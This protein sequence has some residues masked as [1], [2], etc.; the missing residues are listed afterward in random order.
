[1]ISFSGKVI[2]LDINPC[3]DMPG[4]ILKVLF[5]QSGKSKGPITVRGKLNGAKFLQTLVRYRGKWRMYLNTQMRNASGTDVGDKVKIEIEFDPSPREVLM[6]SE[7]N[8]AL[9]KN[10]HA[11][12]AFEKLPPSHQKEILRYLNSLKSK[13]AIERNVKKVILR[14]GNKDPDKPNILFRK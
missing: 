9:S 5:K 1:M 14:L 3:V 10:I 11:K 2:K 12:S 4:K 6:R 7:F 13:D 8:Q